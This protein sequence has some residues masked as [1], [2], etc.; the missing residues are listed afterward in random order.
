MSADQKIKRSIGTIAACSFVFW[1]AICVIRFD[2]TAHAQ[3]QNFGGVINPNS[4]AAGALASYAA[5]G[6]SMTLGPDA[7]LTSNG[8]GTLTV[9]AAGV[10]TGVLKIAGITSG[11]PTVATCAAVCNT[12]Q[13]GT[14]WQ[15]TAAAPVSVTAGPITSTLATGTAPFIITS[16]TPVN[17]LTTV[18]ITYNHSATQQTSVH[19]VHD[20][21]TLGTDCNVTLTG[22][23]VF[24]SSSSYDCTAID[25]TGANAVAFSP[26]SGTAFTLTGTGADSITYICV[27]N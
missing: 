18:P 13:T 21:C 12:I 5:N 15:F 6:G 20:R 11:N 19:L 27:G 4:G 25:R 23:A 26:A 14:A 10:G 17:N 3:G 24:T 2:P 16:T 8:A 22:A 7:G 9:G 1:L